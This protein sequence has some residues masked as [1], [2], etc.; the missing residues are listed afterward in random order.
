MIQV[1]LWIRMLKPKREETGSLSKSRHQKLRILYLQ[2]AAAY[3]SVSNLSKPG[4]LSVSKVRQFLESNT[5]YTK[6]IWPPKIQENEGICSF[7]IEIWCM[8]LAFVDKVAERNISVKFLVTHPDLCDRRVDA[9]VLHTKESN[10]NVRGL[11]TMITK[12]I[13][14]KKIW[15]DKG[16]EFAGEFKKV[17]KL[18]DYKPTTQWVRPFSLLPNVQYNQR[19][20]LYCHM[21]DYRS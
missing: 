6:L 1:W 13:V 9:K 11:S 3:G 21:E 2:S 12:K 15:L 20:I 18:A 14:P 5:L 17:L 8:D 16:T 4:N 7:Q 10:E 19:K